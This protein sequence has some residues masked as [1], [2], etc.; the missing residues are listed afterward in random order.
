MSFISQLINWLEHHQ[1]PCL[2]KKYL[3]IECPG[4]GLQTSFIEL[5]KGNLSQSFRA[6]PALLPLIVLCIYG[7]IYVIFKF[8]KGD[9]ILIIIAIFT[10]ALMIGSYLTRLVFH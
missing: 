4:C 1:R 5:L 8:K 3:G 6:Y 10:G 7:L 9:I 2:Y